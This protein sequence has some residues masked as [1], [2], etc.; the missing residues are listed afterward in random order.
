M[1]R[2]PR[3][4]P[5][6]AAGEYRYKLSPEQLERLRAWLGGG[7]PEDQTPDRELERLARIR[8]AV[9]ARRRPPRPEGGA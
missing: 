9:T 5:P 3:K 8:R 1:D 7:T 4:P 2:K 6:D